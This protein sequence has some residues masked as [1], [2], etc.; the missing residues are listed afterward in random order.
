MQM[1]LLKDVTALTWADF[2]QHPI[3]I[4]V[5]NN[6][7]GEPWYAESNDQTYRPWTGSLPFEERS[8]FPIFLVAANFQLASGDNYP[9]YFNPASRDWDLPLPPRK[10]RSGEFTKPRNWSARRGGCPL[11]VLAIHS[12]TIFINEQAFDFHLRRDPERRK[13]SILDFYAAMGRAPQ[14]VFPVKFSAD[15]ALFSGNM[16]G[17]LDGFYSFPLDKPFEIDTGEAYLGVGRDS[18]PEPTGS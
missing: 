3:W 18:G 8:Q 12:P 17:Q 2:V 7:Y 9:G 6:D 13:Q 5:H 16:S 11:S 10:M 4:G 1:P 15:P 14:A